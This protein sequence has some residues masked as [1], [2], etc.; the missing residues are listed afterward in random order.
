V[1]AFDEKRRDE[2][3]DQMMLPVA[4]FSA[5]SLPSASVMKTRSPLTIGGYELDPG[6][7]TDHCCASGV[8]RDR[9]AFPSRRRETFHDQWFVL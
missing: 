1:A 6:N 8:P 2:A 4:W 9:G 5:Y 3:P 7:V